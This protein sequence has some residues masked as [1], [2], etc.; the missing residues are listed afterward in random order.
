MDLYSYADYREY[1]KDYFAHQKGAVTHFSFRFFARIAGFSSPGFLKMVMDGQRNLSPSSINKLTKGLKLNQ[2]ESA[3]FEALVLFNQAETRKDKD[4][5]FDRLA[6]LKPHIKFHGLEKDQYEYFTQKHYVILREMVALP[7]FKEDPVWI[8]QKL[9]NTIKPKDVENSLALLLRLGLLKRD[10]SG[11]LVQAEA[12]L[13]TPP[14]VDSMEVASFHRVMLD[15]AK[16]SLLD[17]P[18][19]KRH[20]S[21]LTIPIP[22]KSIPEIKSRIENFREEIMSLINQGS[23]DYFEVYQMNI[24]LFP[25][26]RTKSSK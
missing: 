16:E 20:F 1:L 9:K 4:L 25:V 18:A 23:A 2:R 21:S 19:E 14:E 5:Y 7:D 6:S 15:E 11:K 22:K 24:Q 10:E 12:T 17:V 8:A 13:S 26:T 3:F